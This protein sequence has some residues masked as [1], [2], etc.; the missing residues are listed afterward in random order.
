MVLTIPCSEKLGGL[1]LKLKWGKEHEVGENCIL[2]RFVIECI[3]MKKAHVSIGGE[4][5]IPFLS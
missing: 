5:W 3:G 2:M 1:W 4:G